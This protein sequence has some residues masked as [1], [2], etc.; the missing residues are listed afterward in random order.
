MSEPGGWVQEV[1]GLLEQKQGKQ[2]YR[3][4]FMGMFLCMF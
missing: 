4:T 1:P 2:N 3:H